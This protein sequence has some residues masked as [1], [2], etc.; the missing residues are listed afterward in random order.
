MPCKETP[1]QPTPGLCGTQ[2]SEDLIN[3]RQKAIPFLILTFAVC[4]LTMSPFVESS[5][6]YEPP[7]LS[8]IPPI[9]GLSQASNSQ[10]PSH[11]SDSTHE[12]E[13]QVCLMQSMEAPF[14][15]Y[16]L[17]FF[18]DINIPSPPASTSS[19][20]SCHSMLYNHH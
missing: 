10:I 5:Q 9:P 1:W 3:R 19:S 7:I 14:G 16:Q 11:E 20:F 13:P 8:P 6:H 15:K 2:W 12:P 18:P 4:E 17:S